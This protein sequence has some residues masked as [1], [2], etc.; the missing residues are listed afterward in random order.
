M[1]DPLPPVVAE[2][3]ARF[4]R[5]R[6]SGARISID[7]VLDELSP[8]PERENTRWQA[9]TALAARLRA[10]ACTANASSGLRSAGEMTLGGASELPEIAGYEI[11]DCIGRGGMGVVYE[12]YQRS[13]GRR[14]AIKV[15]S[16]GQAAGEDAR[17]RFE[18]EVELV[19]RL[20][21]PGIVSVL[22]SG[23][24]QGRY[25]YVMEYVD[26]RP[27][28]EWAAARGLSAAGRRAADAAAGTTR[29]AI[30]AILPLMASVCEAVDFAHQRG[31][32]HRDLKPSNILVLDETESRR[33]EAV[34]PTPRT[35]RTDAPRH[36]GSSYL[37]P[38]PKI[39]DFGLA[40]S[41]D[42]HSGRWLD[43]TLSQPGQL[44]GT[45]AYMS[46][47]QSRG[48]PAQ[49]SVRSDVY[50]LGA[51]LYEL[52]T[53][54]PPCPSDGP[55]GDVL[56]RIAHEDPPAPSSLMSRA[57]GRPGLA[58]LD[59]I[60]LKALD[61]SPDRRYATAADM[62]ADIR[63][64]LDDEP[65][66][67]RAAGAWLRLRKFARRHRGLVAGLSSAFAL[68]LLGIGGT[69][70]QALRASSAE[71]LAEQRALRAEA[72]EKRALADRDAARKAAELTQAAVGFLPELLGVGTGDAVVGP[73]VSVREALEA[74]A[75]RI[76]ARFADRPEAQAMV[77]AT[78]AGLYEALGM[79]AEAE[80]QYRRILELYQVHSGDRRGDV[81]A[82]LHNLA[83]VLL[84]QGKLDEGLDAYRR[85]L[86]LFRAAAGPDHPDALTVERA[87]A[88]ALARAGRP[89]EAERV[90]RD[91]LDRQRRTLGEE[92]I[93][94]LETL[95]LFARH[96]EAQGRTA[97][98]EAAYRECLEIS[99]RS[100]GESERFTLIV[101][102]NL[103]TML[104]DLERLSEA[105]SMLAACA[106]AAAET[107][108]AEDPLVAKAQ[109]ALGR[110][111][112]RLGRYEEAERRLLGAYADRRDC[113]G[114]A[115]PLC[116]TLAADLVR[117]YDGW[118]RADQ[119]ERWR[120]LA[121]PA[122]PERGRD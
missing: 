56:N 115:D 85:S 105:E 122:A 93:E 10:A 9:L 21:H 83:A 96:L 102:Y 109:G 89:D 46:P 51:I 108:P 40:K 15:M 42:P 72:A 49:M 77:R 55:L 66:T 11:I 112:I 74:G 4:E 54:R 41:I 99:Q 63:R 33:D 32:L 22:D 65:V 45:L 79:L 39:L 71:R 119:A 76:D 50:A 81:A 86:E 7:Q 87:L 53:G 14:V 98:A 23:V 82:A 75:A 111:L 13:T 104:F 116:R 25:Y 103:A 62:A 31:V 5:G 120:A 26:G 38:R 70:W 2:I 1:A 24:K 117:L 17:R 60:V 43:A 114:E 58:D 97:E 67:A 19:G 47:E 95:N 3:V 107:L 29:A 90:F 16:V 35:G 94:R 48:D 110:C 73:D 34:Q 84:D 28:H 92:A 91:A 44:L 100:R 61:K 30:E 121:N 106:S 18:R 20:Q 118:E 68:L 69:S 57:A 64:Y 78:L 59:A 12:A 101:M 27:L 88:A 36:S 8:L 6:R 37:P 52:L 113:C 80:A